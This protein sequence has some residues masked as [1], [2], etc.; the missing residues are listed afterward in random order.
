M[1]EPISAETVLNALQHCCA[2]ESD[3]RKSLEKP[4]RDGD[5]ILGTDGK[6][7][8]RYKI[9]KEDYSKFPEEVEGHPSTAKVFPGYDNAVKFSAESIQELK[10]RYADWC[11]LIQE[12]IKKNPDDLE[13]LSCPCCQ[14]RLYMKSRG[15]LFDADEYDEAA[16][17]LQG[18][19]L[20][21]Q[22]GS[23]FFLRAYTLSKF[24]HFISVLGYNDIPTLYVCPYGDRC[25]HLLSKDG[26][27]EAVMMLCCWY[28]DNDK[29][30]DYKPIGRVLVK[31]DEE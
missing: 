25:A 6:I 5:Y 24:L 17:R 12:G 21:M 11:K 29:D 28:K 3:R 19:V 8:V 16:D 27:W 9:P 13:E 23:Q 10:D 18:I 20:R 30:I 1:S 4:F 26:G 15:E 14:S 7:A 22:D 31:G 2:S